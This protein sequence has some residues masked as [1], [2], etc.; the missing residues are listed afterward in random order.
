MRWG[1][2]SEALEM[3]VYSFT[4]NGI[5]VETTKKEPLLVFLLLFLHLHSV[6]DGC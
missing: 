6:K 1:S 3:D 2:L 4:V 5:R